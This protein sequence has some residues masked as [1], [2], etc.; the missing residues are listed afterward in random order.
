MPDTPM[1]ARPAGDA[2]VWRPCIMIGEARRG[3]QQAKLK[4]AARRRAAQGS[5]R[6]PGR[7]CPALRRTAAG[8]GLEDKSSE[9]EA[10]MTIPN[11]YGLIR[12]VVKSLG[13]FWLE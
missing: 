2:K 11:P 5:C 8:G 3:T 10:P 9:K 4:G 1:C 7:P 13:V 6:A 12:R